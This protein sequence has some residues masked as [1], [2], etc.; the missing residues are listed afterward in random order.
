MPANDDVKAALCPRLQEIAAQ[1]GLPATLRLAAQFGGGSV[2]LTTTPRAGSPL[3][4]CVGPAAAARL[5][6]FYGT[7]DLPIPMGRAAQR[8]Q[9][10]RE[11]L[12]ARRRGL[13][14]RA[15]ARQFGLGERA[16]AEILAANRERSG[17]L[18]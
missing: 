17:A 10:N 11:L 14:V 1:I 4:E 15:L 8:A 7:G 6:A 13:S 2:Y 9:R 12:D 18:K 5:G 16:V 3:V